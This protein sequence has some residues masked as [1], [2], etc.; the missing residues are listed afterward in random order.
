LIED[1]SYPNLRAVLAASVL[2]ATTVAV[3]AEGAAIDD[4]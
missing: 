1:P 4:R 2:L 3:D